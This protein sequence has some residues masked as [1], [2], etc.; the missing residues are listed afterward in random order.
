MCACS[1]RSLPSITSVRCFAALGC[2]VTEVLF[3]HLQMQP[4]EAVLP[5]LLERSLQRGWRVVVQGVSDERLSALDAHLWT[6]RDESF[7]PHGMAGERESEEQPVLLTA[8]EDRVNGAQVRFL[9][10]GAPLPQDAVNYDRLVVLFDGGDEEAVT[11]ART[12]WREAR[13]QGLAVTYWQQD[14]RGRWEQR[15]L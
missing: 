13:M 12:Q 1:M 9:I 2:A 7:L 6:Y 11:A 15:A 8:G 10:D 4:L 5:G 3:Y 14:A